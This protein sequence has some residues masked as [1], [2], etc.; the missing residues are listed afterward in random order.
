M[1]NLLFV[2]YTTPITECVESF[3]GSYYLGAFFLIER[4]HFFDNSG[5]NVRCV[6]VLDCNSGRSTY[7]G[8][9]FSVHKDELSLVDND[10]DMNKCLELSYEISNET[11]NHYIDSYISGV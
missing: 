2:K 1:D 7:H 11:I 10:K 9:I 5:K 4:N 6:I 3:F 8:T